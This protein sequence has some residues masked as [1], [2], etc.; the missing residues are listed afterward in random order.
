[1]ADDI[2]WDYRKCW[3]A[4]AG[5]AFASMVLERIREGRGA[6]GEDDAD[7]IYEEAESIGAMFAERASNPGEPGEGGG[8]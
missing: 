5:A 7:R 6:P 2:T 3:R 4:A 1:M 8:R